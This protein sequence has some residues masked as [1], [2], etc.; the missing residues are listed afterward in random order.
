MPRII[1]TVTINLDSALQSRFSTLVTPGF[2]ES[3]VSQEIAKA[4]P[5]DPDN[6]LYTVTV[7]RGGPLTEKEQYRVWLREMSVR[8]GASR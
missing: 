7:T 2:L 6:L 3:T 8:S 4:L 1:F 5:A